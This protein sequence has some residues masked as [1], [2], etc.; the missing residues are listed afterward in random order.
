MKSVSNYK[1]I[2]LAGDININIHESGDDS[3]AT[4]Y[5]TILA[6]HGMLPAHTLST[7]HLNSCLDHLILK[8]RHPA[9]CF[10]ANTSITDHDTVLLFLDNYTTSGYSRQKTRTIRIQDYEKIQLDLLEADF[11]PLY[12]SEDVNEATEYFISTLKQ[13]VLQILHLK[14]FP[15]VKD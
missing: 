1:N 15:T 6:Y 7:R 10:V 13:I 9:F 11:R 12:S 3:R 4:E 2:V 14:W 5:L 8:T